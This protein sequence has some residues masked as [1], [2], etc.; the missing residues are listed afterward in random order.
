MKIDRT[1]LNSLLRSGLNPEIKT[2]KQLA[3]HLGLDPTS[4]T[5][6][7]ATRDRLG[8]PRYPVVP[9]RHVTK[10]LALFSL[11]A[12]CLNLS[13]EEFRQHCFEL[14]LQQ[15]K[16][17]ND[18]AQQSLLRLEKVAQRKFAIQDYSTPKNSKRPLL[19]AATLLSIAGA[20][21]FININSQE[22]GEF[23]L[24]TEKSA[25]DMNNCWQGYS[26]SLG[27]FNREDKAD[28]CHY[29]KLLHNALAQL[30]A[31][32]ENMDL[33]KS[34]EELAANQDYIIFL[35]EQ[36]DQRRIKDKISINIELGKSELRRL[37]Y[38]AAQKHFQIASNILASSSNPDPEIAADI[39]AYIES[40]K[41]ELN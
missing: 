19:V 21:L 41:L 32:N 5:R 16:N 3:A 11:S 34:T 25:S 17:Q 23:S 2:R 13:D 1:K 15:T 28:P 7:F 38:L 26:S 33:A 18:L 30:K 24:T 12:Q 37:N 40:I 8:N 6:W 27:D 4:L 9:D 14:S 22:Y 20:I 36:L 35:S 39:S 10:I 29:S 31:K